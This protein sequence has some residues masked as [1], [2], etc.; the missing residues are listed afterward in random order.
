MA[1]LPIKMVLL[2]LSNIYNTPKS[3]IMITT[4]ESEFACG[5]ETSFNSTGILC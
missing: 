5:E 2:N 1:F 4:L 3:E